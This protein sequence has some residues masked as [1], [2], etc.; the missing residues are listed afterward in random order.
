MG[1]FN[2]FY[3]LEYCNK[4]MKGCFYYII[5][6]KISDELKTLYVSVVCLFVCLFVVSV[7]KRYNVRKIDRYII[8]NHLYTS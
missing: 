2:M 1:I 7:I 8:T 6:A 5:D 4:V 3:H